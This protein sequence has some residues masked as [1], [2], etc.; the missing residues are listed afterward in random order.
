VHIIKA[1]SI[2]NDRMTALTLTTNRFDDETK[3]AFLDLYSKL[4]DTVALDNGEVSNEET[5]TSK[6]T[7]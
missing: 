4:D 5:Q 1:H 7:L 3:V 6:D 2:F